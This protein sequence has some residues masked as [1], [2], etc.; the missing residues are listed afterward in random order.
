MS[1]VQIVNVYRTGTGTAK[2]KKFEA[3]SESTP[4]LCTYSIFRHE[5]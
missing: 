1:T 5:F 2:L 3:M 4:D